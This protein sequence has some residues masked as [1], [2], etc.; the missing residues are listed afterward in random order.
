MTTTNIMA[1]FIQEQDRIAVF[2]PFGHPNSRQR[3]HEV[4]LCQIDKKLSENVDLVNTFANIVASEE[5]KETPEEKRWFGMEALCHSEADALNLREHVKRI[6]YSDVVNQR[7]GQTLIVG[8]QKID[9]KERAQYDGATHR[10]TVWIDRFVRWNETTN[11]YRSLDDVA[12]MVQA[13]NL[14][15]VE[16]DPF[17]Q[18]KKIE[19]ILLENPELLQRAIA[20]ILINKM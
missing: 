7:G 2:T 15:F 12:D 19:D 5:M 3:Q 4:F 1:S 14:P 6:M 9:R 17:S 8:I 18:E 10:V 11:V 16:K 20:K 13:S